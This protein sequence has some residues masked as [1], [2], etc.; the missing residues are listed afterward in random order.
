MVAKRGMADLSTSVIELSNYLE[1]RISE[2]SADYAK[3]RAQ[4]SL[5][6]LRKSHL[7]Q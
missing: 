7:G 1:K 5:S 2:K 4:N 6:L 3:V